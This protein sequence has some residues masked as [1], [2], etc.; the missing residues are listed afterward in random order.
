MLTDVSCAIVMGRLWIICYFIVV[1][2]IGY[3]V[4]CLDLL[5]LAK[6]GC[7]YSIWFVELAW[8]AC[9]YHLELSSI[10]LDVVSLE[11]AKQEDF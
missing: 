10:M 9:V 7:G 2:L 4:W 11:G 3:R 6:I 1:R 8:K 5:G